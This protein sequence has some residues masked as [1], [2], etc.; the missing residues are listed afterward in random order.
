MIRIMKEKRK[1]LNQIVDAVGWS[2]RCAIL[3]MLDT[4]NALTAPNVEQCYEELGNYFKK[5]SIKEEFTDD[6]RKRGR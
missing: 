2:A 6:N 1:N 4:D 3:C 5:I